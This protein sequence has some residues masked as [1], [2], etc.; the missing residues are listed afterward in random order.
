MYP[1]E[2]GT[3]LIRLANMTTLTQMRAHSPDLA[4][5]GAPPGS[6]GRH[7]PLRA[8]ERPTSSTHV[9]G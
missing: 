6:T 4:Q 1:F 3:H 9:S 7:P 8:H 5:A 2:F